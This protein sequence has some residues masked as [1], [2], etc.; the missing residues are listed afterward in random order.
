MTPA[1]RNYS[2]TERE[3]LA[4]LWAIHNFRP[5]MEG[6]HFTVITDHSSLKWLCNLHNPTERPPRWA[7]EL[8]AYDFEIDH[9]KG[10]INYVPDALSRMY[11]DETDAELTSV[12]IAEET[13]V[14]RYKD[15]F[16]YVAASST[17]HPYWKIVHGRLYIYHPNPMIED[18]MEDEDAW[19]LVCRRKNARTLC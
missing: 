12:E 9:R 1:K 10:S 8:Q 3:C 11:K 17:D 13:T 5:Y 14:A 6:Y 2:V 7:L 15:R 18:L 19:K 4:M 16:A